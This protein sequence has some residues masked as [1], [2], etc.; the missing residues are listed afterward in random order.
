MIFF[1]RF[2]KIGSRQRSSGFTLIELLVVIAIIAM[3]AALLLP[4]LTGS[5]ERSRIAYCAN[6]L[7]QIG[8]GLVMYLEQNGDMFPPITTD[9]AHSTWDVALLPYLGDATN[10][11]LCPSDPYRGNVPADRAPR[12]YAA[13]GVH[14]AATRRMPFGNSTGSERLRMG[15]LDMQKNDMILIGEYPGD[16]PAN[17]GFVGYYAFAYL[18]PGSANCGVTHNNGRG[19]NYLLAS[20]AVRYFKKTEVGGTNVMWGI[21]K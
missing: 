11:F 5:R 20:L 18:D 13:N 9:G 14:S 3:L 6:N 10:I 19:G 16:A 4:A 2:Q 8:K 7:S 1:W 15:D 21:P 12:S 17:R